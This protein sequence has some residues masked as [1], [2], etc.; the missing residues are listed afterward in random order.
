PRC[1]H[2]RNPTEGYPHDPASGLDCQ[3]IDNQKCSD[4]SEG[5]EDGADALV[6]TQDKRLLIALAESLAQAMPRWAGC[7]GRWHEHG[8]SLLFPLAQDCSVLPQQILECLPQV[9]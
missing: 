4:A 2:R 8:A 6:Y 9:G 3:G 1:K 7:D 5:T